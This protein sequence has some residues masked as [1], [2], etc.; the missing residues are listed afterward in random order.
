M[1]RLPISIRRQPRAARELA[2][3]TRQAIGMAMD[4]SDEAQ[5]ESGMSK[6]IA[7]F[8]RVDILVSNAGIQTVAPLDEFEFSDWKKLIAVHLDGALL[9][10]RAALRQMY[11]QDN[12]GSIIYIGSVHSKEAFPSQGSLCHRQARIDRACQDSG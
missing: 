5:V 10:T 7:H 3:A 1:W 12:G 2:D 11:R 8:G 4:V 9:T 6:V